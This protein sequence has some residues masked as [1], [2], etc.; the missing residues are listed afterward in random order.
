MGLVT[1]TIAAATVVA[2]A[3]LIK[4]ILTQDTSFAKDNIDGIKHDLG[5]ELAAITHKE[6]DAINGFI[7]C[8]TGEKPYDAAVNFPE[9]ERIELAFCRAESP[10]SMKRIL[11]IAYHSGEQVFKRTLT[12]FM[13]GDAV[14]DEIMEQ[15][16]RSGEKMVVYQLYCKNGENLKCPTR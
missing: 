6:P 15:L 11:S 4:K 12:R 7:A 16:V 5:S 14:P 2:G 13:A 1:K 9:I 10:S 8:L 3:F